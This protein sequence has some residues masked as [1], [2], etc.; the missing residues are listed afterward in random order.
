MQFSITKLNLWNPSDYAGHAHQTKAIPWHLGKAALG[1]MGDVLQLIEFTAPSVWDA[2]LARSCWLLT[3]C[4][5]AFSCFSSFPPVIWRQE[6]FLLFLLAAH[7]KTT[8]SQNTGLPRRNSAMA[9]PTFLHILQVVT[10]SLPQPD[11]PLHLPLQQKNSQ[12]NHL[13]ISLSNLTATR[14]LGLKRP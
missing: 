7:L 8:C 2:S 14:L 4:H 10:S 5:E 1:L 11:F 9:I 3:R 12:I 6:P 13:L